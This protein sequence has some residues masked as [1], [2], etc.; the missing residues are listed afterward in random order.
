MCTMSAWLVVSCNWTVGWRWRDI[1]QCQ[2]AAQVGYQNRETSLVP[3]QVTS[4]RF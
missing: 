1:A 3:R 4:K 2:E